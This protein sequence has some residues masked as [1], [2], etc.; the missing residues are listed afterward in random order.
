MAYCDFLIKVWERIKISDEIKDDFLLKLKEGKINDSDDALGIYSIDLLDC[1]ETLLDTAE[2]MSME[3]NLGEPTIEMFNDD[4]E[5]IFDN[6]QKDSKVSQFCNYNTSF[7]CPIKDG[8]HILNCKECKI[9][10]EL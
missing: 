7:R 9:V 4:G 8:K 5:G 1:P 6:G 10:K 2:T 3:E